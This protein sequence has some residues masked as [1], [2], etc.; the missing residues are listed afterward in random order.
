MNG[1]PDSLVLLTGAS[2]Y[3]GGRLLRRLLIEDLK[4]RCLSRRPEELKQTV[5]TD[6]QV[7]KGD[8]LD[9]ESLVS[10]LSGVSTAFYLIHSMAA[11]ED[12]SQQ[13]RIAA[14]NFADAAR[15]AGVQR[16]IYV[17]GLGDPSSQ[18]SKHLSS[19]QETGEILR[20]SGATVIELQASIVIGSGSLSFE[21]VRSLVERLPAMICPRW[22]EVEA[23]PIAIEDLI[24]YLVQSISINCPA[25][26][27]YQVG[28][29]DRATYGAVMREYA[30]QRGLK[31]LM[32][33]VPFL[34]PFLSSLW[35][36]LVTP[37]YAR[38]G[39]KLVESLKNP[40]V[41]TD[42]AASEAFSVQP[43]GLTPAIS[44]AM[45]HEETE[46]ACTRW[47]DSVS[48]SALR[49]GAKPRQFGSRIIDSRTQTV[50]ASASSA[51]RPIQ[52]IGGSTG[53]YFGTWLWNI[54]GFIDILAGGVGMRR[55]RRHP[56]EL[57]PGDVLDFWRVEQCIPGEILRLRAEMKLPGR[58]WLQFETVENGP[59][60]SRVTQ[61]AI[62]DPKGLWGYM[63]WYV[64]FPVHNWMFRGMLRSICDAAE[65]G[66][67]RKR[68]EA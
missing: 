2:G 12:F 44:R 6:V 10:A 13:D 49:T 57:R 51:F 54:R 61:T 45:R 24:E 32:I 41:V 19:R 53:W 55:G 21:L 11:G 60:S 22:L 65:D 7:V 3:I 17:G 56:C 40:T 14:S 27:I 20:T 59:S 48:S 46:V 23:Q 35:L 26:T 64:L 34:T 15:Q 4:V 29:P 5:D 18:L 58:A 43:M 38:V 31:R 68:A 33:P 66:L 67:P 37:V 63:Y 16:I 39:R 9:T 42:F 52:E 47:S 30:R 25:S 36:G 50:Q 1:R 28:G 62:F 8:A